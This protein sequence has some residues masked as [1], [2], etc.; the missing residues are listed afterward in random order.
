MEK[1]VLVA[2]GTP[3]VR[4]RIA[5][6]ARQKNEDDLLL[7]KIPL[8]RYAVRPAVPTAIPLLYS[9]KPSAKYKPLFVTIVFPDKS[10]SD[11]ISVYLFF[12][13][14]IKSQPFQKHFFRYLQKCILSLQSEQ[15]HHHAAHCLIF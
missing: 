3:G 1:T 8:L 6:Q 14:Q 13:G 15:K 4:P 12:L 5:K 7:K 10:V 2:V 11:I 9:S